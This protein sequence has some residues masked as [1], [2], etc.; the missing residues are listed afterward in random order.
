MKRMN[1][2][3]K[4]SFRFLSL[5]RAANCLSTNSCTQ[6]TW[7]PHNNWKK[8]KKNSLL[9]IN[10]TKKVEARLKCAWRGEKCVIVPPRVPFHF[11]F[12]SISLNTW[13]NKL[14]PII[15]ISYQINGCWMAW[16]TPRARVYV[17]CMRVER[18]AS[19]CGE[20]SRW[21][22]ENNEKITC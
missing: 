1:K 19:M 8:H 3:W 9:I 10:L 20:I 12:C 13:R 18:H 5:L 15:K 6:R 4:T 16:I 21:I 17:V 22:E 7:S 11:N 2:N 14:F